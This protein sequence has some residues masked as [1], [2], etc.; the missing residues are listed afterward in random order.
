MCICVETW[1]E[2]KKGEGPGK[3][4]GISYGKQTI[5][6]LVAQGYLEFV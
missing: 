2:E 1:L 6:K 5:K 4:P 3:F